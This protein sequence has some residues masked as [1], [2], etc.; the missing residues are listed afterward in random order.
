M[1]VGVWRILI[2]V[3]RSRDE[4]TGCAC[5]VP[6]QPFFRRLPAYLEHFISLSEIRQTR[7]CHDVF[8]F[9]K[10]G[11]MPSATCYSTVGCNHDRS[12]SSGR[13]GFM[14][15]VNTI[16]GKMGD[17]GGHPLGAPLEGYLARGGELALRRRYNWWGAACRSGEV[18]RY[19]M[20][21]L[22]ALDHTRQSTLHLD[23]VKHGIH[24]RIHCIRPL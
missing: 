17:L 6:C 22:Q 1:A 10:S 9:L 5:A 16:D 23:S 2:R 19:C 21:T 12:K 24:R 13:L 20:E 3:V 18:G 4:Q 7:Y 8:M 11:A 14:I 15:V